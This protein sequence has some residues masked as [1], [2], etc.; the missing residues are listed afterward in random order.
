VVVPES[1]WG[2][3]GEQLIAELT[4]QP[5]NSVVAYR[6]N[7]R[8]VKTFG[9]VLRCRRRQNTVAAEGSYL[10]TGGMGGMGL[11]LAQY[12]LNSKSQASASRAFW[13]ACK[14]QWE[15]W[16]A[17]HDPEDAI[18]CKIQKVQALEALGLRFDY[19]CRCCQSRANASGDRAVTKTLWQDSRC[20]P[21]CRSC[22]CWHEFNNTVA[23]SVLLPNLWERWY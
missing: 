6:G 13:T 21:R 18:S 20:H 15:Q 10:I 23:K 4:A 3:L 9:S 2:K 11:V 1:G 22:G 14:E 5:S 8:W 16:L 19:Q 17:T 7:H 12:L